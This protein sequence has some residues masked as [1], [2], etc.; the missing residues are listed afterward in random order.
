MK[1]MHSDDVIFLLG[2]GASRDAGLL[3]S[4]QMTRD[5]EKKLCEDC[6]WK[7]FY[8][9]YRAVKSAIIHGHVFRNPCGELERELNIEEFVNVLTELSRYNE[10]TIYPFIASWN[11]ELVKFAGRDFDELKKF[12]GMIIKELSERWVH[13]PRARAA[14]YYKRLLDF[15]KELDTHLCVFSLNYDLCVEEGCGRGN[16]Y[17]GFD[18]DPDT[19][20]LTWNDKRMLSE[21]GIQEYIRL[22][23]LHGSLDWR[24][25]AAMRLICEDN[26][27]ACE[28]PED[29]QLIFGTSNKLRYDDPY[30]LLLSVF[31]QK[32][33]NAKVIVC[34]GYS[35]GDEH[36]N[37]MIS[38][39]M[40]E[41]PIAKLV[42]V[43][44]L[45]DGQKDS[46]HIN[47]IAKKLDISNDRIGIQVRGARDFFEKILSLDFVE[48]I[49]PQTIAP[50]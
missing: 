25:N 11:M 41:N 2:A 5:L 13:L 44:Y 49:M 21:E 47:T 7:P 1:T 3:T 40:L 23:K 38:K 26:P 18:E 34:V 20:Q 15:A 33:R 28:H 30:L 46:D 29:Y 43:T 27:A 45:A 22:F 16:V 42:S 8:N 24:K 6:N 17:R 19:K 37:A 32:V 36:I 14:S 31:R 4:N 10:H 39:A 48:E 12:R 9:L 35:Y 50:F